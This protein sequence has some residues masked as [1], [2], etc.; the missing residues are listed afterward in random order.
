MGETDSTYQG[1]DSVDIKSE[2]SKHTRSMLQYF[3]IGMAI[4]LIA[5]VVLGFGSTYGRQLVLGHEIKGIGVVQTDWV[6]HL[7][8]TVFVS[9]MV[10]FLV[11]TIL[12]VRGRVQWH[13]SLG[14][15]VGGGLA[16]ALVGT[17]ILITYM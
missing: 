4:S 6:I 2:S 13:M 16:L 9:W 7:H 17:G 3:W 10:F 8:A 14:K 15:Y 11:Q 12:M 5:M 1:D